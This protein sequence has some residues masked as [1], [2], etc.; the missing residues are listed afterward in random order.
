MSSSFHVFLFWF[1]LLH[2]C[3][4]SALAPCSPPSAPSVLQPKHTTKPVKPLAPCHIPKCIWDLRVLGSVVLEG[5]SHLNA[6]SA[7]LPPDPPLHPPWGLCRGKSSA[8]GGSPSPPPAMASLHL[9]MVVSIQ[10]REAFT[11]QT[12][13]IPLNKGQCLVVNGRSSSLHQLETAWRDVVTLLKIKVG[14]NHCFFSIKLHLYP[15]C[16]RRGLS[17]VDPSGGHGSTGCTA[18]K[19]AH[20]PTT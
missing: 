5:G 6:A 2:S 3:I 13:N 9:S 16:M 11:G 17:D 7:L 1:L 14:K 4:L 12:R 19:A 8:R 15:S 20:V 10:Q 18:V